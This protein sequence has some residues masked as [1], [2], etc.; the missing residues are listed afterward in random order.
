MQLSR[1]AAAIAAVTAALVVAGCG[2]GSDGSDPEPTA[3]A[4]PAPP[5]SQTNF[6]AFTSDQVTAAATTETADPVEIESMDWVYPDGDSETVYD[7]LI[8]TAP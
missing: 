7:D 3:P 6:T 4:P 1:R 8:A 2:G 5:T